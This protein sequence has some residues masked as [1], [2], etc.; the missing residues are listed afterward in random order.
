MG[1]SMHPFGFPTIADSKNKTYDIQLEVKQNLSRDY[2]SVEN[3][4]EA[5]RT[6][7]PVNKSQLIKNPKELIN[8]TE[9]RLLNVFLN[10]EARIVMLLFV[11]F[12]ALFI[13]LFLPK[14]SRK[15]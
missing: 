1:D 9:R 12:F 14:L 10:T 4:P 13:F 5:I 8:F 3:S 15:Q 7:Y 6:V 2:I 11:P